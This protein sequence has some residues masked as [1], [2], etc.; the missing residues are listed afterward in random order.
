PAVRLAVKGTDAPVISVLIIGILFIAGGTVF[1]LSSAVVGSPDLKREGNYYTRVLL[2]SGHSPAFA[3]FYLFSDSV[4]VS[5]LG[6]ALL[7]ALLKNRSLTASRMSL[8]KISS[9]TD[10]DLYFLFFWIAASFIISLN[11]YHWTDGMCRYGIAAVCKSRTN[12]ISHT[13]SLYFCLSAYTALLLGSYRQMYQPD[14][15]VR[16]RLYTVSAVLVYIFIAAFS[17]LEY[18]RDYENEK[19]LAY[20]D[21]IL[22]F[23][24][25]N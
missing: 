20:T 24:K 7:T 9:L 6:I 16:F 13:V 19:M 10:S 18:L 12:Y 14:S 17:V 23:S 4:I 1:D 25:N 3:Y 22:E 15:E 11:I 2:N 8:S 21:D 5:G